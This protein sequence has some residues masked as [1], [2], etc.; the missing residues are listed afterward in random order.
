[1]QDILRDIQGVVDTDVGYM[2]GQIQNPDYGAVSTRLTA[3]PNPSASFSIKHPNGY[4]CHYLRDW[5][6][7]DT[8]GRQ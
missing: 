6:R 7:L 4:T 1:M 5:D 3:M 8:R 2:G